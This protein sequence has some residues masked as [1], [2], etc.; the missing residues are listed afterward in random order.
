MSQR[1]YYW[2]DMKI[3]KAESNESEILTQIAHAAKRYWNYPEHW[4]ILWKDV[5]TIT[6]DFILQNE[7]C[8][9]VDQ[10]KILGFY[11]LVA[12]KEA[13]ILEHLW[14]SPEHIGTGLGRQLFAHAV[15][16][17]ISLNAKA[18]DI[19]SEPNA[20]DF[21]KKMGAK[22]IGEIASQVEETERMLPLLRLD[23]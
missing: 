20:E 9:A 1:F 11:A 2:K 21:Y 16:K 6:P 5:L 4:L 18:I 19:V 17:A 10:D 14:I 22:R 3:R 12:E 23:L 7:V 13:L 15:D 8:A